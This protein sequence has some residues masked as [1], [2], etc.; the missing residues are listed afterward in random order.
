MRGSSSSLRRLASRSDTALSTSRRLPS[1]A[2]ES[3]R[4]ELM[5]VR[6]LAPAESVFHVEGSRPS[7]RSASNC[8]MR[9]SVLFPSFEFSLATAM[10]F[11]AIILKY[12]CLT[13]SADC[14]TE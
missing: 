8:S 7:H 1:R 4:Q 12:F 11:A 9:A 14:S 5:S 6:I 10:S 13:S 3:A 2:P